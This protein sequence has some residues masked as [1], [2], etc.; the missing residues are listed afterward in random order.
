[1]VETHHERTLAPLSGGK[2]THCGDEDVL[3]PA[4]IPAISVHLVEGSGEQHRRLKS[5]GRADGGVRDGRRVRADGEKRP[6]STLGPG[7]CGKDARDGA[8][9]APSVVR[10]KHVTTPLRVYGCGPWARRTPQREPDRGPGSQELRASVIVRVMEDSAQK[11]T[12]T[13]TCPVAYPVAVTAA[14]KV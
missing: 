14:V 6:R 3:R 4:G 1:M 8:R 10:V 9:R 2:V 7:Q 12:S 5:L 13:T 11:P